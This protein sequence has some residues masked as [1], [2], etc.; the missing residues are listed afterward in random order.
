RVEAPTKITYSL[1]DFIVTLPSITLS[2]NPLTFENVLVN[3]EE[4][5]T[6]TVSGESLTNGV[7][8]S[9]NIGN[10][11]GPFTISLTANEADFG[12][13]LSLGGITNNR[14]NATTIYVKYKPTEPTP[15]DSDIRETIAH[16]QGTLT[17][18]LQISATAIPDP[19]P[20]ELATFKAK[21]KENLITLEWRTASE[22][23]NS[24]FEIEMS[25][26]DLSK[27]TKI[28][29]VKSKAGNSAIALDYRF[30]HYYTGNSKVLYFRLKQVDTD[31]TFTYSKTLSVELKNNEKALQAVVVPNPINANSR[32]I[33]STNTAGRA[34][35]HLNALNGQRVLVK[36]VEVHKGTNNLQLPL[37]D[38]LQSG[39]YILTIELDGKVQ[40]V[41]IIKQ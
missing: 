9:I 8:V 2:P 1:N 3:G 14:L 13:T 34:L 28:S 19:Q 23:D 26:D 30:T 32:V 17:E 33:F 16:T 40:Q 22:T 10:A 31:G 4:T 6:Y 35:L 7:P 20:V 24:H 15:T 5:K 12:R 11:T 18:N 21:T 36:E 37:P 41:K 39:M 38:R 25:E 27:F 29:T